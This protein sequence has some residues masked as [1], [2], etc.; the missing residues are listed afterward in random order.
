MNKIALL[1]TILSA[2]CSENKSTPVEVKIQEV[3]KPKTV[4]MEPEKTVVV[5]STITKNIVLGKFNYRRDT[6]F[7][8]VEAIHSSKE[9]YLKKQVYKAFLKMY[10]KAEAEGVELKIVSGARNF[11]HQKAIWEREWKRYPNLEPLERAKKI[12][13]SISM[14]STSRHH[15]GTEVDLNNLEN[16]YFESGKGKKEYDWLVKNAHEF[17]FYQVYTDKSSGRTGYDLEKWHWSY[18]P[19]A[20]QYLSYYNEHI[21]YKDIKDFTG[22]ELAESLDLI[23]AYVN[24]VASSSIDME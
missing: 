3:E 17:G 10:A 12:L 24:G 7:V 5:D 9:I 21:E 19:L 16:F 20:S 13:E 14:P 4:K 18:L 8:K 1:I 2:T 22:A 6:T 11:Y 23:S 15:W